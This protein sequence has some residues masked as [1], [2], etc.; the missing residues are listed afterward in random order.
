MC[1][2]AK[3]E[4]VGLFY[5]R[6]ASGRSRKALRQPDAAL[7]DEPPRLRQQACPRSGMR[8][9]VLPFVITLLIRKTRSGWQA[10]L[11]VIILVK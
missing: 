9:I 8:A 1:G 6:P 5:G 10:K 11:R 7:D 4:S 3:G 2:F